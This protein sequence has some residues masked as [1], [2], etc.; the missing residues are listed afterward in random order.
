MFV[1]RQL[2]PARSSC[3]KRLLS[4]AQPHIGANIMIETYMSLRSNIATYPVIL[5]GLQDEAVK[6]VSGISEQPLV[7]RAQ[8]LLEAVSISII[9]V[10][11]AIATT[12]II[13]IINMTRICGVV[14][15]RSY[16]SLSTGMFLVPCASWITA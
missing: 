13:V 8:P 6:P 9:V 5:R 10:G 4:L 15:C 3:Q 14:G 1:L 12:I 16:G 7:S 11:L 2:Q